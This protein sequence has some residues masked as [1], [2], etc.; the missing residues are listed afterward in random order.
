M[1]LGYTGSGKS[2]LFSYLVF[3][4]TGV[5][6]DIITY[7]IGPNQSKEKKRK[8]VSNSAANTIFKIGH[9]EFESETFLPTFW[10]DDKSNLLFCDIAGFGDSG[11]PLIQLIN[12]FTL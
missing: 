8:V 2:T 3:G 6:E 12:V 9:S 4:P 10:K 11:P 1:C 7:F 5:K